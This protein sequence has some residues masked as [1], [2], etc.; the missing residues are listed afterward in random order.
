M[1]SRI[2]IATTPP[3]TIWMMFQYGALVTKTNQEPNARPKEGLIDQDHDDKDR[4]LEDQVHAEATHHQALA[5][6]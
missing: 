1:N 5:T 6:C 2:R 4:D 3:I